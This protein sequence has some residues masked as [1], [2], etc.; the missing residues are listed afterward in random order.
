[1]KY[2]TARK[3]QVFSL[4]LP[5]Q[6]LIKIWMRSLPWCNGYNINKE[7]MVLHHTCNSCGTKQEYDDNGDTPYNDL[8]DLYCPSCGEETFNFLT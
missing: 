3:M 6:M 5:K 1:M 8:Y 2:L 7:G 4:N